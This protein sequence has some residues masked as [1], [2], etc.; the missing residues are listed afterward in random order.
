[1][2]LPRPERPLDISRWR[3]PPVHIISIIRPSGAVEDLPF[4]F[5]YFRRSIRGG[6]SLRLVTGGF[7][8]G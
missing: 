5:A 3:E 4:K 6:L 8:T 7:T 2:M 1:M